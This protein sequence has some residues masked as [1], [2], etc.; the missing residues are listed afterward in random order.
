MSRIALKLL[1]ISIENIEFQ[2]FIMATSAAFAGFVAQGRYPLSFF[3]FQ[4]EKD[5]PVALGPGESPRYSRTGYAARLLH[6]ILNLSGFRE[7]TSLSESNLILGCPEP[8]VLL[9]LQPHQR[10][11]H[12]ENTF[13]LG[14]KAGY[15]RLMKK[16]ASRV[17]SF[18]SFYPESYIIPEQRSALQIAFPSSPLWISK[19]GGG[20]RGDGIVVIDKLP[21]K[22]GGERVIQKY[23]ANPLLI[24]G[25]KFDLRF[26]VSVTSLDPLQIYVHENGL[27]R[28]ATEPYQQNFEDLS[29]RSAHLTN[30]S[31]NKENAA[32]VATDDMSQDGTGNKWTHRPFWPWLA[33]NGF[34]PD[35]IRRKIE[36]AFVTVII[37]A[38]ETF[39]EQRNHRLSFE[40]FGFDVMLDDTGKVF[41]LEVN[42]TPAMGTSSKLDLFVKGPVTRDLFNMALVPKPGEAMKK[43][44]AILSDKSKPDSIDLITV[45][46]YELTQGRLGGFRCIYPTVERLKSH[47]P[48]LVKRTRADLLLE[49]WIAM[50]ER[51]RQQFLDEHA[52]PFLAE[53]E[54]A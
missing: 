29:N 5:H 6:F 14:S 28:L 7:T 31:I 18:P 32:F 39:L 42:V 1:P 50:G 26:Y 54:V 10:V 12:Y 38:R 41:I 36:D 43:V 27:V 37:S 46:E 33:E 49:R 2:S 13:S 11:S 35:D 25:L 53:L 9:Q 16:F 40:V 24:R 30:F 4:W 52:A 47:G 15:H 23:L 51:D 34:D 21:A 22:A 8:A 3:E 44:E 48:L 20:A 45:A 17:G 19:P